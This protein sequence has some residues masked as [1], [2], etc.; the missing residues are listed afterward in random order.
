MYFT[1]YM[2]HDLFLKYQHP[3]ENIFI[4]TTWYIIH[5]NIIY[6]NF[7]VYPW[8]HIICND[9]IQQYL[10]LAAKTICLVFT[11]IQN[12]VVIGYSN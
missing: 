8:K 5:Y 10:S 11:L 9:T 4:E 3:P 2:S 12:R 7:F 6:V 1:Y